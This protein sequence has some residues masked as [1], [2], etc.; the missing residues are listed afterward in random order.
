MTMQDEMHKPQKE[1]AWT[2]KIYKCHSK[3]DRLQCSMT[4]NYVA[5]K[6]Y[7]EP[8]LRASCL[9]L[10]I[11]EIKCYEVK[12]EES[13]KNWQRPGVE[14]ISNCPRVCSYNSQRQH[15]TERGG[16]GGKG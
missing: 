15:F 6:L 4:H 11:N 14:H 3:T 10:E 1:P 13:E 9:T 8:V 16:G 5:D 7:I 2:Q 12:I